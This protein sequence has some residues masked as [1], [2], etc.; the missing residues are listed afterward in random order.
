[1]AEEKLRELEKAK[2]ERND[3]FL[4]TK[5]VI[6]GLRASKSLSQD[7]E[8]YLLLLEAMLTGLKNQWTVIENLYEN[9]I[10]S[11]Q[12]EGRQ[13]ARIDELKKDVAEL[14]KTIDTLYSS[15]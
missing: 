4:Q 11:A 5:G 6:Q 3:A 1:M 15:K 10:L 7:Q 13:E 14:K 8:A 12:H 2:K 9:S